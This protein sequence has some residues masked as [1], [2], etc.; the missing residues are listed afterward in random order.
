MLTKKKA[1]EFHVGNKVFLKVSPTKGIRKFRVQG[2]LNPRY[3]GPYENIKKLNLVAYSLD[4][5]ME[6]KHVNNVFHAS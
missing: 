6:L 5:L 4:L 2:K 3:I 1:L